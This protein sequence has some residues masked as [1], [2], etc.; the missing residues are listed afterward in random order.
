MNTT[1]QPRPADPRKKQTLF[2]IFTAVWL[3]VKTTPE[4]KDWRNYDG[5]DP[6]NSLR[7]GGIVHMRG[8]QTI[9]LLERAQ[10]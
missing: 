7:F 9:T 10:L 5:S 8:R 1:D 6:R 4:G 2:V 3:V